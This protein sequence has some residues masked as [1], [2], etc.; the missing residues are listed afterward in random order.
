MRMAIGDVGLY[1]PLVPKMK[2]KCS[3]FQKNPLETTLKILL[4]N[5]SSP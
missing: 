4:K 1:G 2:G 3:F 5:S